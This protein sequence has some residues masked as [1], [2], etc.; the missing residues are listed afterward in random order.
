MVSRRRLISMLVCLIMVSLVGVA[1]AETPTEVRIGVYEP[2][3]G[4]MAA[5]GQMTYEGIELAHQQRPEVLG[6]PVRLILV[7]NRSD[8][9]K[10]LLL[11]PVLFKRQSSC[12]YRKLRKRFGN[13]RRTGSAGC[14]SSG[15]GVFP[16]TNPL[17]TLGNDYYFRAC[18]ID[19][20]FQ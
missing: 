1:T 6:L 16:P 19:P 3:T 20:P 18:F 15:H 5:G 8:K 17:V 2:M 7:D 10:Q 14:K 11:L 13:V 12:N 4:A 9:L